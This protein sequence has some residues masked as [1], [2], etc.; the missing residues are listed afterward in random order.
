MCLYSLSAY[1]SVNANLSLVYPASNRPLCQLF[2]SLWPVSELCVEGKRVCDMC[3]FIYVTLRHT[4]CYHVFCVCVCYCVCFSPSSILRWNVAQTELL[5]SCQIGHGAGEEAGTWH[6]LGSVPLHAV[7]G[8]SQLS[9][10][11]LQLSQSAW[12]PQRTIRW[13]LLWAPLTISLW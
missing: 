13:Q 11:P 12:Q 6:I 7:R 2:T 5:L 3:V 4:V 9:V 1:I 10:K 8:S